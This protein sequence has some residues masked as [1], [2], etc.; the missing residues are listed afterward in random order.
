MNLWHL[1][2]VSGQP[3]KFRPRE[4]CL[5]RIDTPDR[6][7]LDAH[8]DDRGA[9]TS[10]GFCNTHFVRGFD[11][12]FRVRRALLR[13]WAAISDALVQGKKNWSLPQNPSEMA[14][15]QHSFEI[16]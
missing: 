2:F 16:Y 11:F 7:L 15:W 1:G 13:C 12:A 4:A 10:R 3:L 6:K 5:G 8:L 9:I 14:S